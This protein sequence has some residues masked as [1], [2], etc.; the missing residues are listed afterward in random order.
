MRRPV[1]VPGRVI[2]TWLAALCA[3]QAA[4]AA[5]QPASGADAAHAARTTQPSPGAGRPLIAAAAGGDDDV[6]RSVL[7]GPGG[8][9]YEPATPGTWQRRFGGGIG[10]SVVGATFAGQATLFAHGEAAPLF[11][12]EGTVWHAQPLPNRGPCALG[13]GPV[14]AL[15]I[16]RHV[17][18][19]RDSGWTR[20]GSVAGVVT[21]VW[22]A[23]PTRAYAATA[24]GG[25]WRLQGGAATAVPTP[26]RAENDP[27]VLLTGPA[28]APLHGVT[29]GGAVLRIG[30]RITLVGAD[31][32]LAGWVAQVAAVDASG[33]LWALGW[34]PASAGAPAQAV[35]ARTQGNMLK[36]M[37]TLAGLAPGERF[38]AL[39]LDRAGGVLWATESGILRY[40]P[41]RAASA[42]A[43]NADAGGAAAP[44]STGTGWRDGQILD[45]LPRSSPAFPGRGPARAR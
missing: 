37:E 33:A 18:T 31:P 20:L 44:D 10:P 12:L 23:T 1:R 34:I 11:R 21:A 7:V 19:W 15:A 36:V 26:A 39:L 32:A 16:G 45:E 27:V 9:V 24:Q 2:T 29:R 13:R 22:A 8:Q 5:A 3:W 4:T 6:T 30:E 38:I 35:L 25:L 40:R 17:Y 43:G 42:P 14:A 28:R 41:G